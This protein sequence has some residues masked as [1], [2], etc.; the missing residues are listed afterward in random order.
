M[1]SF[2]VGNETR[3]TLAEQFRSANLLKADL[4]AASRHFGHGPTRR[5][6]NETLLEHGS[7]ARAGTVTAF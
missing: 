7:S 2:G 5:L 1:A 4:Q 6:R 3:N